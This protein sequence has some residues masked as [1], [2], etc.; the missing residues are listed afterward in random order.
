MGWGRRR[1]ETEKVRKS[2]AKEC[3]EKETHIELLHAHGI[4]HM[5]Q[6]LVRVLLPEVEV[7]VV[8]S[9]DGCKDL[10]MEGIVSTDHVRLV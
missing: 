3:R 4:E 9:A 8:F 7:L 5:P 2:N 1:G 10:P 6:E